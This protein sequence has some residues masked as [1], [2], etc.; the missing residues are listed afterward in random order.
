MARIV[1]WTAEV[2]VRTPGAWAGQVAYDQDMVMSDGDVV[3]MFQK[4]AD[5]ADQ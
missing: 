1:A 2:P 3:D 4:S 5:S